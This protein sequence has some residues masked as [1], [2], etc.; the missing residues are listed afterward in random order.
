[1]VVYA[2]HGVGRIVAHEQKRVAGTERECVVVDLAA[3]LRVTLPLEETVE[4]LRPVADEGEL[5]KVRRT[6]ASEPAGRD[7][8][9]TQRISKSKAKLASG[10]AIELAEIVRDGSRLDGSAGSRLSDGEWRLY[11]Q[12]RDLLAREICSAR[13]LEQHEADQ[14]IDDQIELSDQDGD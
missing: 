10:R 5:E 4:R 7:G 8:S 2:P 9:W 12:A 6:L 11:L 3:G 13:G 1:M 14:W